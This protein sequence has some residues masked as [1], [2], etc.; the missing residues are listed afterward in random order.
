MSETMILLKKIRLLTFLS[1]ATLLFV[2]SPLNLAKAQEVDE[3]APATQIER[4]RIGPHPEYTRLLLD[5]KGP[6][7]Y[8]VSAN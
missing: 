1:L 3:F 2:W 7:Q 4:I 6:A 8:Q 5:I